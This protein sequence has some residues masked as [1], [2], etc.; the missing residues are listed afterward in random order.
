DASN[1]NNNMNRL[2]ALAAND[3]KIQAF[4]KRLKH[5]P[6]AKPVPKEFKRGWWRVVD[7]ELIREISKKLHHR[8]IRERELKRF[9][10]KYEDQIMRACDRVMERETKLV[11]PPPPISTRLAGEDGESMDVERPLPLL[12][13]PRLF[14][15][16]KPDEHG[17]YSA[18][19]AMR[20][21]L[22]TLEQVEELEEKGWRPPPRV[23]NQ[24]SLTFRASCD[25]RVGE[26]GGKDE[27]VNPVDTARER[28]LILEAA[29]ERRYIKAPL[30]HRADAE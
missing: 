6:E 15:V 21:D 7:K 22:S 2:T 24:D 20:L 28:L 1:S 3:Q 10:E 12:K 18:D 14:G 25:V 29:I 23:S 30:G 9:M 26:D 16:P 27:R 4:L 19:V 5:N 11:Y 13:I 8:G 17:A